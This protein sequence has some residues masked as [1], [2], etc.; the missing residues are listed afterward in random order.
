MRGAMGGTISGIR[1]R[2]KKLNLSKEIEDL[3]LSKVSNIDTTIKPFSK[4]NLKRIYE[5]AL[6]DTM[7]ITYAKNKEWQIH[8]LDTWKNKIKNLNYQIKLESKTNEMIDKAIL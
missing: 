2:I 8:T 1:T 4:I 7:V 6:T 3:V 5:L